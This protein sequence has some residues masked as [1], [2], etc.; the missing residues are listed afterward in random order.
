M[1]IYPDFKIE[2]FDE[3]KIKPTS[4]S[5]YDGGYTQ[6][7]AK[8]TRALNQFSFTHENLEV[9]D[10]EQ[11]ELFFITNQGLSFSFVH[12]LSN[13]TFEVSFEM[14]EI[15]FSYDKVMKSYSTKI[16]VQEV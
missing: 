1:A 4:K 5:S 12:P 8:Y 13:N 15:S 2:T 16:I 14:D 3:K 7:V 10:K 11:L 6:K 9:V